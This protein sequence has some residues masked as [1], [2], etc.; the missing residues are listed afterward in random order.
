MGSNSHFDTGK[1]DDNGRV[2]VGPQYSNQTIAYQLLSEP[3]DTVP[4]Y[5]IRHGTREGNKFGASIEGLRNLSLDRRI[6]IDWN[7]DGR[8]DHGYYREEHSKDALRDIKA[9]QALDR[10]FGRVVAI[11]PEL[12][13]K[14]NRDKFAVIGDVTPDAHLERIAYD[15][16]NDNGLK[17]LT[18]RLVNCIEVTPDSAP[19]LYEE[20]PLLRRHTIRRSRKHAELVH[21]TYQDYIKR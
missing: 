16:E 9:M 18:L 14:G 10:G 1:V 21:S 8:L 15:R 5:F 4:V 17:F 13:A 11:Y 2:Y 3:E 19:E 7:A 6:A 20:M 12:Y